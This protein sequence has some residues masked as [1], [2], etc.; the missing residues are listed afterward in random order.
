MMKWLLVLTPLNNW[1]ENHAETNPHRPY[2]QTWIP[3]DGK[4][5]KTL[6]E[7]SSTAPLNTWFPDLYLNV[8]KVADIE[9]MKGGSWRKVRSAGSL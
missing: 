2:K 8:D 3:M 1:K 7:T 9:G 6:N 5:G 4:T